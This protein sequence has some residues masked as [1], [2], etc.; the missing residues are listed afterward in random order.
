MTHTLKQLETHMKSEHKIGLS[1][2]KGLNF[3]LRIAY[4]RQLNYSATTNSEVIRIHMTV[5]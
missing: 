1:G 3:K 5:Y 2:Q 4:K